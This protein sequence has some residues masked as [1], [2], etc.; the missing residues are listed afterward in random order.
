MLFEKNAT[1]AKIITM[2]TK[3]GD[4]GI[5][6]FAMAAG[7][8]YEESMDFFQGKVFGEPRKDPLVWKKEMGQG[9]TVRGIKFEYLA[10]GE[11]WGNLKGDC[12]LMHVRAPGFFRH[13]IVYVPAEDRIYD[14]DP[15]VIEQNKMRYK[16]IRRYYAVYRKK[17]DNNDYAMD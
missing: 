5:C 10:S 8:S 4:C 16:A 14:P 1:M 13:W 2:R 15:K 3:N 7:I 17:G 11:K 9:L 12:C 6:A